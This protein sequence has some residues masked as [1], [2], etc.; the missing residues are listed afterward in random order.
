MSDIPE[1]APEPQS[2][3]IDL[4]PI[5]S[6]VHGIPESA[7]EPQSNWV[8]LYPID[9]SVHDIPESAPEP[10]SYWVGLH[11]GSVHGSLDLVPEPTSEFLDIH[12]VDDL[13]SSFSTSAEAEEEDMH[14][15][16]ITA[17]Q[18]EA[19]GD[20]EARE[21]PQDQVGARKDAN[22]GE[23]RWHMQTLQGRVRAVAHNTSALFFLIVSNRT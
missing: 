20:V 5:D 9:R 11:D 7:P 2:Y 19:E 16:D 18:D 12:P 15:K 10:R 13:E 17:D 6:S 21:E 23:F 3:W 14:A 4:Y 1:S 8:D 22:S